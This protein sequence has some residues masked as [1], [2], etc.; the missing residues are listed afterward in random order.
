MKTTLINVDDRIK[1]AYEKDRRV[2]PCRSNRASNIGHPCM[3]YLVYSRKDWQKK[4]LPPVD[5]L[6][7][8][9][10]GNYIETLAIKRLEKAGF[11]VTSQQR[12]FEDHKAGITGHIDGFISF[13]EAPEEKYPLE[14]KSISQWGYEAINSYEDILRSDKVWVKQYPAQMQLYLY[15]SNKERGMFYFVNKQNLQG[16]TI[17][18]DLDYSYC[19]GILR[20]AE[21]V[22]SFL[23]SD[24]YP[25][26]IPY[27]RDVCGNC[28][29]KHLCMPE[30]NNPSQ[31]QF[32]ENQELESLLNRR[33]ELEPAR[34]E[35]EKIDKEVK[36]IAKTAPKDNIIIGGWVITRKTTKGMS[37]AKPQQEWIRT[38]VSIKP[39]TGNSDE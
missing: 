32:S 15:L 17:W 28:D 13:P 29:F 19:E 36:E 39:L 35:Y 12:D 8:F 18:V 2:Y 33:E 27:D 14:I 25:E 9:E 22:N 10:G 21:E 24:E 7:I 23:V 38:V 30:Q 1:E 4:V 5:L 16:K 37:P 34:K 31:I 20:K 11:T 3:R 26:R 6:Y